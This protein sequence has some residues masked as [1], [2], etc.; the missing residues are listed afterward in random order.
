MAIAFLTASFLLLKL[1]KRLLTLSTI[2]VMT[3]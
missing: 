3:T 2:V 1:E